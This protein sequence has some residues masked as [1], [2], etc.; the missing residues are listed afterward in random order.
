MAILDSFK[1]RTVKHP[2][3]PVCLSL[4]GGECIMGIEMTSDDACLLA[5]FLLDNTPSASMTINK[6]PNRVNYRVRRFNHGYVTIIAIDGVGSC[7]SL[8]QD[9]AIE[10]SHAIMSEAKVYVPTDPLSGAK[11]RMNDNLRGVFE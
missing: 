7:F 3:H 4:F 10:L 6:A 5:K 1:V 9:Q 8:N 11:K 2:S